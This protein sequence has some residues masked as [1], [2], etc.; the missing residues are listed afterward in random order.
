QRPV[1]VVPGPRLRRAPELTIWGRELFREW[2]LFALRQ[3]DLEHVQRIPD[4]RV[5]ADDR[6]HL[7][8]TVFAERLHRLVEA[9]LRQPLA[10]EQ[11]VADAIDQRLILR[12]KHRSAAG[13][14]RLDR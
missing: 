4:Q 11:L 13:A 14:D 1:F 3:T 12:G 6:D 10:T 7:D 5:V 2:R 8:E 9:R